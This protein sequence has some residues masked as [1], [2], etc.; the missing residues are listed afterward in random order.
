MNFLHIA[1]YITAS[2]SILP[3]AT[4]A[5]MPQAFAQF[6]QAVRNGLM[7]FF[8]YLILHHVA[9][10]ILTEYIR[11]A[12][13]AAHFS[14]L[15]EFYSM[16]YLLHAIRPIKHIRFIA[17]LGVIPFLLD[18]FW[19]ST[20]MNECI[21]STVV[22]ASTSIYFSYKIIYERGFEGKEYLFSI[23][24]FL[25]F[26][27]CLVYGVFYHFIIESKSIFYLVVP[28]FMVIHIFFYAAMSWGVIHSNRKNLSM[29]TA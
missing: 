15:F 7:A 13:P 21:V 27:C 22:Y 10:I 3:L 16:L 14:V 29:E 1:Y 28:V 19:T 4:L 17:W 25:Y 8:V 9:V 26:L 11:D 23:S 24:F 18:L 5:M 6:S 2:F 20:L 12:E